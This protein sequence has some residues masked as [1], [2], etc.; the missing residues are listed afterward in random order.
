[1][2]PY[3]AAKTINKQKLYLTYIYKNYTSMFG[4]QKRNNKHIGGGVKREQG[5]AH[6]TLGRL[7]TMQIS[8][9]HKCTSIHPPSLVPTVKMS[10]AEK[11][12]DL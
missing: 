10:K 11:G 9:L 12:L 2:L 4:I 8:L 1:M 5:G 3:Y 7:Y 6:G